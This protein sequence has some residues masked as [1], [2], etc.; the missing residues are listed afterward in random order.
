[1]ISFWL[2][3][4]CIKVCYENILSGWYK[5]IFFFTDK[6]YYIQLTMKADPHSGTS[7]PIQDPQK[8]PLVR[9]DSEEMAQKVVHILRKF[10][11][12]SCI[13]LYKI[14]IYH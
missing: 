4:S 5:D 10:E 12:L 7:L 6:K 1:M 13:L 8:R 2:S 11:I 14:L 3:E 9:C